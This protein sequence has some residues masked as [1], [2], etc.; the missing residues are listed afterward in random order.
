MAEPILDASR[1]MARIGQGVAASVA[2]HVGMDQKAEAGALADALDQAVDGV[3]R[4]RTTA[5]A[6]CGA[7]TGCPRPDRDD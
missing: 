5:L 1:V 6:S 3:G 7:S 2:E 4:E